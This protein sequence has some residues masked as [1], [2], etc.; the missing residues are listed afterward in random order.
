MICESDLSHLS[1]ARVDQ[2]LSPTLDRAFYPTNIQHTAV[3]VLIIH[4]REIQV[5]T[6]KIC[7]RPP[8]PLYNSGGRRC[9]FFPIL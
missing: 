2:V 1:V 7:H 4:P 8:Q 3:S 5:R 6:P 9:C